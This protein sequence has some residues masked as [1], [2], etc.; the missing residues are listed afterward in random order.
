MINL[1]TLIYATL[2]EILSGAAQQTGIA[3][4]IDFIAEENKPWQYYAGIFSANVVAA[5][6]IPGGAATFYVVG[7]AFDMLVLKSPEGSDVDVFLDGVA[8]GTIETY[9]ASQAWESL[10]D[11]VFGGTAMAF[12][13][14]LLH[15]IDF[16]NGAP[17][18][19]NETGISWFAFTNPEIDGN[20]AYA[21]KNEALMYDTIVFRIADDEVDSPNASLPIYVPSGKTLAELQAYATAVAPEIDAV[22]D[23]K[24]VEAT[25]TVSLTLP[26]GLKGEPTAGA[27]NERG[28]LITFNTTGPHADSVRI[29]AMNRTIMDGNSFSLSDADVLAFITRLTTATTAATIRPRTNQDYQYVSARKSAKSFRK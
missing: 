29:P 24:I 15:R 17:G 16:I 27:L 13:P 6:A 2:R 18:V 23:G 9:A 3:A 8:V 25:V 21:L 26:G 1:D 14:L 28:G 4:A 5:T 12:A 11:L 10:S 7:S 20:N 19:G 22:T